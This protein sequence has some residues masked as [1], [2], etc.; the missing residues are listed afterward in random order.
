MSKE[1]IRTTSF[2]GIM[3]LWIVL[4]LIFDIFTTYEFLLI[5]FETYCGISIVN[6]IKDFFEE[7][8]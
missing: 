2:I 4:D 5:F 7:R 3:C 1:Y 8:R 6:M